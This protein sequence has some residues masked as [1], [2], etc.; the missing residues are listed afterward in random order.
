MHRALCLECLLDRVERT[1]RDP[2][3]APGLLRDR[4]NIRTVVTSL[5]NRSADP[6]RNPGNVLFMLD[7]HYL[8]CPGGATDL[9]PFFTALLGVL[10]LKDD[11]RAATIIGGILI[12]LAVVLIDW[13]SS[14]R[15]DPSAAN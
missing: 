6:A 8:F 1:G 9:E 10:V 15:R 5:G 2:A 3:W 12:V 11:L 4:C 14:T 7:A 13:S